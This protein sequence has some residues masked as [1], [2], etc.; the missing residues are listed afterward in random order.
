MSVLAMKLSLD[1]AEEI[2]KQLQAREKVDSTRVNVVGR[3][4][5]EPLGKESEQNRRVE[6]QW[7]TV[8]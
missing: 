7:L 3:G 6:A 1:R 5:E 2:R 4:W 8:E